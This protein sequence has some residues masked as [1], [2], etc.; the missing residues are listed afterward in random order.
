MVLEKTNASIKAVNGDIQALAAYLITIQSNKIIGDTSPI[1]EENAL[2]IQ[3]KGNGLNTIIEYSR[4]LDDEY[5]R[6]MAEVGLSE[7]N[8]G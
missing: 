2:N 8:R 7:K 1:D 3:I 6:F 4:A 5:D